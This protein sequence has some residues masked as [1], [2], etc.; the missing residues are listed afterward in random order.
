[1][2]RGHWLRLGYY[3]IH[4]HCQKPIFEPKHI[5]ATMDCKNPPT[6]TTHPPLPPHF[7]F[8][9]FQETCQHNNLVYGAK[10][11]PCTKTFQN[12]AAK[13][14]TKTAKN[15]IFTEKKMI[16]GIDKIISLLYTKL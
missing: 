5:F 1:M 15:P 7:D 16:S 8:P 3:G 14:K 2:A 6:S 9:C 11:S 4:F 13:Y 10:N 12:Q